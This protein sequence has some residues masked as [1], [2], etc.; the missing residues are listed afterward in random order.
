MCASLCDALTFDV[1]REDSVTRPPA[2]A[3]RQLPLRDTARHAGG[4]M[5]PGPGRTSTT[6]PR[7]PLNAY[8]P[9]T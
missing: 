2:A 7:V 1:R 9:V 6:L 4:F 5:P 8:A 3:S